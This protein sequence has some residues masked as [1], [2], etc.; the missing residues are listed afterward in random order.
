MCACQL[1]KGRNCR[2]GG[3]YKQGDWRI[4]EQPEKIQ[5]VSGPIRGH[6]RSHRS[7]AAFGIADYLWERARPRRGRRSL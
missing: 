1:G 6:A 4:F 3:A 5:N 2:E 7:T